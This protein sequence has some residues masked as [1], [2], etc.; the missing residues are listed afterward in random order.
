MLCSQARRTKF[1]FDVSMQLSFA[2]GNRPGTTVFVFKRT[3]DGARTKTYTNGTLPFFLEPPRFPPRPPRPP[4]RLPH[5]LPDQVAQEGGPP[6]VVAPQSSANIAASAEPGSAP[7]PELNY[8]P[9]RSVLLMRSA[10]H[11]VE[12]SRSGSSI[13]AHGDEER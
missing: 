6:F 3:E 9:E 7:Q 5:A 11:P 8:P 10:S 1:R 2:F 13:N 12:G 4:A